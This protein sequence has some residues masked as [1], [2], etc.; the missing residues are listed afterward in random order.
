MAVHASQPVLFQS[1]IEVLGIYTV[2]THAVASLSNCRNNVHILFD[3]VGL[4]FLSQATLGISFI[5]ACVLGQL[6]LPIRLSALLFSMCMCTA[7][8]ISACCFFDPSKLLL[9]AK[10]FFLLSIL[11]FSCSVTSCI[12]SMSNRDKAGDY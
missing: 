7:E 10:I 5:Q 3:P 11:L 9:Q 2:Y 8:I 1:F 6:P 12:Y 4:F